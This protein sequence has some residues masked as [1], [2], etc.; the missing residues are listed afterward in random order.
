[1]SS[2]TEFALPM[3]SP[4]SQAPRN[5]W[6]L[7]LIYR[8]R[9][10]TTYVL[11]NL[12]NLVRLA[13]PLVLGWAISDLLVG[14]HRG[15]VLFV[16]QHLLHLLLGMGRRM[17][18]T[19]TF[20]R[21]YADL[22][23]KL[24]HEQR[25]SGVETSI[26]AARSV[27]SR[28]MVDFFERDVPGVLFALYSFAGALVMLLFYDGLLALLCLSL[29]LPLGLINLFY[30]RR[31][32]HL[33]GRLNDRLEREVGVVGRAKARELKTHFSLLSRFRIMLSDCEALNFGVMEVFILGL[34]AVSLVRSCQM[35]AADAGSIFAVFR[36]VLMFVMGLDGVPMLVQQISRIRDITRRL[37]GKP[38]VST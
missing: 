36:Y 34:L 17:Y 5:L 25:A 12:E 27:L 21:I 10:I 38:C 31:T 9:I 23:S 24:V 7:F 16:G 20:T 26:V 11:F 1:M 22:A 4:F 35:P 13:Q 37:R 32:L 3:P 6:G 28:D 2:P 33:T 19:R 8:L 29:L 14:S 30:S 18:D 15:L